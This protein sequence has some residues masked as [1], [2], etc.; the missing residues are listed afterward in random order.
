MHLSDYQK[1][2][3]NTAVYPNIGC[4]IF[5]P[6]LGL[7]GEAGEVC[8]KTKKVMR[9]HDGMMPESLRNNVI[10]ELGDVMWYVAAYAS[11]LDVTLEEVC[12]RNLNKL[13]DR[14]DRDVLK[15]EGDNR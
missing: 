9:D 10:D 7:A 1:A 3:S 11:E 5:Y 12:R 13:H 6:A 4:N 8:N 15:G 2:A 14:Q